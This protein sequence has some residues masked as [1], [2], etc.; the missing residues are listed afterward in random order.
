MLSQSVVAPNNDL[1]FLAI[2]WAGQSWPVLILLPSLLQLHSVQL[3]GSRSKCPGCRPEL[4]FPWPQW[5]GQFPYSV[6]H[7][8]TGASARGGPLSASQGAHQFPSTRVG[9]QHSKRMSMELQD[10]LRQSLGSNP[11]MASAIF[12]C[13]KKSHDQGGG[14]IDPPTGQEREGTRPAAEGP[15]HQDWGEL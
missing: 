5:E 12:D 2:L 1:L 10:H 14:E 3:D 6:P 9:G 8:G 15:G 7:C 4:Q 11:T 13:T